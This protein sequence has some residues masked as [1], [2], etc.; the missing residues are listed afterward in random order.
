VL[1]QR[2]SACMRL[3]YALYY[4]LN[5]PQLSFNTYQMYEHSF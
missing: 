1:S 4:V 2:V 3:C 5:M